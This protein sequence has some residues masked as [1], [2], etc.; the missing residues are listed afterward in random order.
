MGL[1][2]PAS[3]VLMNYVLVLAVFGLLRRRTALVFACA[4]SVGWIIQMAMIVLF[5]GTE[6]V[7]TSMSF[8]EKVR[9]L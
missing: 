4:A 2:N 7:G 3:F 1:A 5:K 8:G 9:G 6:L